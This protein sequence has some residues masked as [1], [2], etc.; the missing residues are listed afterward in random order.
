MIIR[1]LVSRYYLQLVLVVAIV[2]GIVFIPNFASVGNF[3][4]ILVQASFAG[5]IACGMTLLISAGQFDLS[6]AGI[7]AISAIAVSKI[8]P[9]TTILVAVLVALVVGTLLGV[10][11][12]LVV[13]KMRIPAF[14][15]TL[16]TFN[17]YTAVAFIWA[18]GQVLPIDSNNY[19]AFTTTVVF[20]VP[21]VFVIFVV[22]AVVM[23]LVLRKTYFGRNA[24]GTGSSEPAARMAGLN[25][26][27]TKIIAFA[28]TGL[29][30]GLAGVFL[31]GLLSSANAT[32]AN[33]IELNAITIA[34]VGG[35]ALRG[36]GGTL[37]GTF[38]AAVFI[39]LV[40]D[41]LVLLQVDSYW[42]YIAVGTVLIAAL[43]AGSLRRGADVRGAL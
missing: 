26:D 37:L 18:G 42:Q 20:G 16:G 27:G 19:L 15:A 30:T 24:R 14:I 43:I 11:N 4:T 2:G 13:T 17:V 5:L 31:S 6:V 23:Y 8:L 7:V 38:T 9:S 36:G 12:G 29:L 21:L 28:I 22:V 40:D 33:G 39:S 10:I 41:A 25:V 3:Q 34:V 35:T 32:M 1:S